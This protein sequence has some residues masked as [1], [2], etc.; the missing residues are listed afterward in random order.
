MLLAAFIGMATFPSGN[1][2]IRPVN[3]FSMADL[4]SDALLA[5]LT[6]TAI[7][8]AKEKDETVPSSNDAV[9]VLNRFTRDG[10]CI[11]KSPMLAL[12]LMIR[13]SITWVTIDA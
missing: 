12:T 10:L 5:L 4:S 7:S 3:I 1:D 6:I 8:A 13:E 9:K 2:F 11:V